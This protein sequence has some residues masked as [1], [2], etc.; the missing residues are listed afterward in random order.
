MPDSLSRARQTDQVSTGRASVS[1]ELTLESHFVRGSG[2]A[3]LGD[4]VA[5][6]LASRCSLDHPGFLGETLVRTGTAL[7]AYW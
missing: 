6:L 2:G 3:V 1:P 5:S 7:N 4:T